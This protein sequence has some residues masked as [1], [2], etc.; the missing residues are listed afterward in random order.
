M[1][2]AYSIGLRC[3][4]T[5][6]PDSLPPSGSVKSTHCNP[7]LG[8]SAEAAAVT[9]E[10]LRG[11]LPSVRQI[12]ASESQEHRH[13]PRWKQPGKHQLDNPGQLIERPHL[14]YQAQAPVDERIRGPG[15]RFPAH[16]RRQDKPGIRFFQMACLFRWKRSVRSRLTRGLY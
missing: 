9:L 11:A 7:S 3:G 10:T 13:R 16:E 15:A 1:T 6:I 2:V 4:S 8:T 12:Q 5:T 14:A